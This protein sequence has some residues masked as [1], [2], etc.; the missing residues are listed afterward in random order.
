VPHIFTAGELKT[1]LV[2]VL[3]RGPRS[4][5]DFRLIAGDAGMHV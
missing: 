4:L 2:A 3:A 5:E 1:Y